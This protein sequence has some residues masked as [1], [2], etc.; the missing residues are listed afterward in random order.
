MQR[1]AWIIPIVIGSFAVS[2]CGS[3]AAKLRTDADTHMPSAGP[4]AAAR[5]DESSQSLHPERQGEAERP[6]PQPLSIGACID[7]ALEHNRDLRQ[8]IS[9]AERSRDG[10]SIARSDAYAPTLTASATRELAKAVDGTT[11]TDSATAKIAL[12]TNVVGFTVAPYAEESWSA[13]DSYTGATPYSH[14]VGVSVSRRL[15]SLA[16]WSRLDQPLTQA[17]RAYASAVNS[18]TLESRRS[19]FTVA[20][21]FMNLQRAQTRMHLRERRVEQAIQFVAGVHESVAD[22]LKAPVEETNA[23]IDR[24]QAEADLLGDRLAVANARDQ[25]LSLLDRPLGS[26]LDIEASRVDDIHPELPPL[27]ADIALVLNSH[28]EILNQHIDLEQRRDNERI[29]HDRLAPQLTATVAAERRWDAATALARANPEDVVSLSFGLELPMDGWAGERASL[30]QQ[31]RLLRESRLKL[32]AKQAELELEVRQLRRRIDRQVTAVNLADQRLQAEREKFAA[33]EASYRTGRVDNLE[34]TRA[35]SSLDQAEVGLLES[36]IDL[37]L[38]LAE[39][40]AV[41]P[42][43]LPTQP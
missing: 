40:E 37:V 33:T 23:V 5:A 30:R 1:S 21:A 17:D 35:R 13:I 15:F 32:R 11:R 12:T 7:W 42:R 19:A 8:R 38:L 26:A 18:L 29:Q 22:G 34:L 3:D 10:I 27:E 36:R 41:L 16:E 28:E 20:S 6:L 31:E 43:T 9:S 39:R 14:R 25:V 2:G 24:N 4:I